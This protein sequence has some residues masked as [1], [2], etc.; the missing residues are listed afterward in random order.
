MAK[1]YAGV[2]LGGTKTIV[3]LAEG[4][5]IVER[6]DLPTEAPAPTLAAARAWLHR[7]RAAGPLA[8]LGIAAFGPI[9]LDPQAADLGILQS[10]PK[11]GWSGAAILPALRDGLDCPVRIDT[12]VNAAALAEYR[13]GAGMGC[14][15]LCYVTIGTG[16]GGGVLIGGRPVHG[17]LHPE[18]GHLR[19]RRATGDPFAGACAFHADC[20]EGLVAGPA[21]ARRFDA[22]PR[23]VPD[24]HPGWDAVASDLAE[25]CVAILLTI[26]A[27][28]ILFGGS[29][30]LARAALLDRVRRRIV[31]RLNGYLPFV[32][33]DAIGHIVRTA[34]LGAD[35]GPLG[36]VALAQLAAHGPSVI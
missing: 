14:D 6:H 31:D 26:S 22:D 19:L 24:D 1:R 36:A 17:A 12:D 3:V 30:G 5:R 9:R 18:L 16:V 13:W 23:T 35:A 25:L 27:Q 10:T 21:L 32:D 33:A 29:V 4:D 15:S 34:A 28:R 20:I 11:P 2:E 8:G 7:W